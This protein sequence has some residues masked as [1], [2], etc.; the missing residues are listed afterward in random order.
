MYLGLVGS[1]EFNQTYAKAKVRRKGPLKKKKKGGVGQLFLR[2]I[3]FFW[4][5]L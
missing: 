3:A 4:P 2:G 1:S 5:I